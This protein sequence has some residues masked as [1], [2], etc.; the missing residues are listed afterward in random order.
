MYDNPDFLEQIK[1][2][3]K[4]LELMNTFW[5]H[6]EMIKKMENEED[7]LEDKWLYK[8]PVAVALNKLK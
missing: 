1:N 4:A 3:T 6:E 7:L 2:D 5:D 8:D